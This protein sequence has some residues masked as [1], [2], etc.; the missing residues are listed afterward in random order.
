MKIAVLIA[1]LLLGLMFTVFGAN[2]F[3]HFIPM[4]PLPSGPAGQFV[5][6]LMA[7]HFLVVLSVL[8]LVS[9]LLLLANRY[10]PLALTLLGPIVVNIVLYHLLMSPTG[11]GMAAVVVILWGILFFRY[12]QNFSGL[13][14]QRVS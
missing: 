2:G 7:S 4:G 3:L 8:Y 5:S 6:A 14:V 11:L 9:G 1:R 13:F 10:V 12:R